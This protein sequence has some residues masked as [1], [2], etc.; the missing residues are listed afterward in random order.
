MIRCLVTGSLVAGSR[1]AGYEGVQVVG[2]ERA[3]QAPPPLQDGGE[4]RKG[5]RE[6]PHPASPHP[7]PLL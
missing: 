5:D 2:D 3:A 1:I 4:E 6:G 7:L